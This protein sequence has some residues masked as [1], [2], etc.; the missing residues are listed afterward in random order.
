MK[1][2]I[3][4]HAILWF[5]ENNLQLSAAAMAAIVDP[6]NDLLMSAA[7]YWEVA[8]KLGT[9]RLTL[10]K[11]FPQFLADVTSQMQ[12]VVL[13]IKTTHAVRLLT[14]PMHHRDPFDR[15]LAAQALSEGVSFIS[16]D[17]IFDTYGVSRL[18]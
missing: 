5:T 1:I 9:G 3:D 13:P 17:T 15:M 2:L 12:L 18:W 8:I 11:P 7:S 10:T 14:L 4:T 16:A 6:T